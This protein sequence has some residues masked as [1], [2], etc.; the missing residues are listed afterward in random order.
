GE[1]RGDDLPWSD[2]EQAEADPF[3]AVLS[4]P[5]ASVGARARLRFTDSPVTGADIRIRNHVALDRVFGGA[6]DGLLFSQEVAESGALT[7][8]IHHDGEVPE[9]VTHAL[10]LALYDLHTGE[11]GIGAGTTRGYG[12]LRC[13]EP[14]RLEARRAEALAHFAA[15]LR[16]REELTAS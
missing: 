8:E 16:K 3:L 12:T 7:L 5:P 15:R 2:G 11:L 4:D 1:G 10:H 9:S 14:D 6:T 13:T